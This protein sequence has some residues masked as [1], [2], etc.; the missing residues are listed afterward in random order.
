[1]GANSGKHAC[2]RRRAL[3]NDRRR[4]MAM[5][6]D[7]WAFSPRVKTPARIVSTARERAQLFGVRASS[8]AVE[9]FVGSADVALEQ[10][11]HSV[12]R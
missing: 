4:A 10:W 8:L 9:R 7:H 3:V 1:M 5:Y 6:D 11:K 12:R 2:F